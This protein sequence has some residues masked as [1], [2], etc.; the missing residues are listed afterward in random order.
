MTYLY[1]ESGMSKPKFITS[2]PNTAI[3]GDLHVL[4]NGTRSLQLI[5]SKTS[6]ISLT[7]SHNHLI[8]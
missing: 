4:I 1:L 2:A 3:P 8:S 5:Q 6:E 7:L